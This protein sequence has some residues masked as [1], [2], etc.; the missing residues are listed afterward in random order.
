[1]RL[2]YMLRLCLAG[3]IAACLLA[4][5]TRGPAPGSGQGTLKVLVTD[6]PFPVEMLAEAV[7][8]ITRVEVRKVEEATEEPDPSDPAASDAPAG[9]D[10]EDRPF[11]TIFED[12]EGREF[13]LLDLRNGKT[14]LLTDANL[15]AGTYDQMRLI[16]SGGRVTLLDD[17]EDPENNRVFDLKVPSGE[18][19]GI[20][21]HFT[22]EVPEG[23]ATTLILD[24][25]LSRAFQPI[26]G[27]KIDTPDQIK[28]F[29]FAPSL[30]MRLIN[31]LDAG[32]I[33]G[34]VTDANGPLEGA[35]VT[36]Y[37][38]TDQVTSTLSDADGNYEVKGL[39]A[40]TYKVLFS[41]NGYAEAAVINVS[42]SL[43]EATEL[44]AVLQAEAIE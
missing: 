41:K 44:N 18:Q 5:C 19:T 31:I 10:E 28:N 38:G 37:N 22:F 35:T 16:V 33:T 14:D 20:K 26:P 7:V 34:V 40:G 2:R 11:I 24:V 13:N 27:G 9:E 15:P 43:G 12:P 29:K 17:D 39:L 25:D 6:K 3:G 32:S 42:V 23:D 36:V 21:L 8:T 1:M 4:S 30:A